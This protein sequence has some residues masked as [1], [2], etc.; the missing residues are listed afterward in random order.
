[1]FKQYGVGK[2]LGFNGEYAITIHF[3]IRFMIIKYVPNLKK[4]KTYI[5]SIEQAMYEKI[6]PLMKINGFLGFQ[7]IY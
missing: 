4:V 6:A 5:R 2:G 1:M 3:G 7:S